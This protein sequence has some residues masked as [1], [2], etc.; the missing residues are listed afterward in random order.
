MINLLTLCN[1]LVQLLF[2][3]LCI[4]NFRNISDFVPNFHNNLWLSEGEKYSTIN[5]KRGKIGNQIPTTEN[6]INPH[7]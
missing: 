5:Q 1:G 3:E 2:L 6:G 7:I 4:I